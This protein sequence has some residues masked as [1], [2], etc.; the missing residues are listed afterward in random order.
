VT[1]G[2]PGCGGG[3]ANVTAMVLGDFNG[4]GVTDVAY[5]ARSGGGLDYVAPSTG[6]N[7]YVALGSGT[8]GLPPTGFAATGHIGWPAD[9]PAGGEWRFESR[10][11]RTESFLTVARAPAGQRDAILLRMVNVAGEGRVF[12]THDP[13]AGFAGPFDPSPS[14]RGSASIRRFP[15]AS[16]AEAFA[17]VDGASGDVATFDVS[18]FASTVP[19]LARDAVAASFPFSGTVACFPDVNADGV[20]DL[21]VASELGAQAQVLLGDG[22][23]SATPGAGQGF[24]TR[25]HLRGMAFP[26][27]VGDLDGDGF[28]DVVAA[29]PGAGLDVL[30]GGGGMLAWGPRLSTAP[31][32]AVAIADVGRGRPSVVYQDL[33]GAYAVVDTAGDGSFAPAVAMTATTSDLKAVSPVFLMMLPADLATGAAGTDFLSIDFSSAGWFIHGI[34]NQGS[35]LVDVKSPPVPGRDASHP[36]PDQC[37]PLPVG[38]GQGALA[39]I[40]AYDNSGGGGGGGLSQ[41]DLVA[42]YG[43]KVQSPDAPPASGG[44]GAPSI[45]GWLSLTPSSGTPWRF[46]NTVPAKAAFVGTVRTAVPGGPPAGTAVFAMRTDRLYV[47]EV[48]VSGD[49]LVAGSWSVQAYAVPGNLQVE[50]S[51]GTL[52]SLDPSG[53]SAFDAVV[54]TTGGVLVLRRA[55]NPTPGNEYAV[56]QTLGVLQLPMGIGRLAAGSPGDV[57]GVV[58]DLGFGGGTTTEIIPLL[59]RQDGT[60]TVR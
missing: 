2:C 48:Q 1:G 55:R 57:I 19:A 23:N 4:D 33:A 15:T 27:A 51:M 26:I 43:T 30:F 14:G 50:P 49:P 6:G 59:N 45:A 34:L 44:A 39:I 56:A 7:L 20:P 36:V 52:G 28:A 41:R 47:V 16:G 24:G 31:M 13:A 17:S 32:N 53:T 42:V 46:A 11:A 22:T 8:P 12:A 3:G 54:G 35:R 25:T 58:T 9:D 5:V 40:C 60:G 18:G 29:A 21:V 38:S 37:W 10:N